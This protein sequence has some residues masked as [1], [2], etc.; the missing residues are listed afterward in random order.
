VVVPP[1]TT[2]APAARPGAAP[3]T[4][5]DAFVASTGGPAVHPELAQALATARRSYAGL[6]AQGAKLSVIASPGNGGKPVVVLI[7]PAL[8]SNTDP[9]KPYRVHVHYHGMGSTALEPAA[10]SPLKQRIADSFSQSPPTVFV[11]PHSGTQNRATPQWGN[12]KDTG[13]TAGDALAGV[14]GARTE[15]TVSAHS[16]GRRAIE[17]AIANGGLVADRL[18][19]QDAFY[20]TQPEG[21]RAVLGWMAQHPDAKVR[22]LITSDGMSDAATIRRQARFPDGTVVVDNPKRGHWDAEL[23][24]W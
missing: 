21:P 6:L 7:P 3:S 4:S 14:V 19:L 11:L 5:P 16:L 8:A 9:S 15:L 24:A 17:S 2:P 23:K 10:D 1:A 20:R 12:V 13:V 18:D 22:V